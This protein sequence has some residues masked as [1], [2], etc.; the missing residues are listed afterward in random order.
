[1][2]SGWRMGSVFGIPLFID[3]SLFLI[4]ILIAFPRGIVWQQQ[5]PAWGGSIAYAAGVAMA[6]L[7][8]TSVLLHELG[9]SLVARSQGI[10][11]NSITLFIFGGVA[12]IDQES[13]TPGQAFQVAIAGP[14]VSFFLFCLLSA[15][16][17]FLPG[18]FR[19]PSG[20]PAHVLAHDLAVL[21]LV[22]ATFNLLPGLPLDGGQIVKALVWKLT[23]SRFK[24]VHWAARAGKILGWIAITFGAIEL[25]IGRNFSGLWILLLGLFGLRNASSYDQATALQETLLTIKAGDA[26]T[27]EFR[28]VDA[29]ITL[30]QFADDYLLNTIAP[31]ALYA[32]SN[33]RYR[34]LVT[35]EDLQ[36]I[37]RSQWEVKTVLDITHPLTEVSSVEEATSLVDVISFLEQNQ[38][39]RITVLSPA[40]AVSGVIDRGD[41]VQAIA[42]KMNLPV[43]L[44]IIR[45]IKEEGAYPPGFNV[46]ALAQSAKEAGQN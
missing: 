29:N 2:Q 43:S 34:G 17:Y 40:G 30:R 31:P 19:P 39:R 1:M 36:Q 6:I 44:D 3:P 9:H 11:V 8:F 45:R 21:N 4:L 42:Q 10:K 26:M 37:E 24:G 38:L 20:T 35:P 32:A 7:L 22:L 12:S 27:R 28:V 41:V 5:Y 18:T 15:V 16:A 25:F 23:G 13:K 46:V 14:A 33:G